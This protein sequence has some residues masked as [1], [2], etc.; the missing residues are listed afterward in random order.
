MK[1]IKDFEDY[2]ITENGE[3]Y[4][5]KYGEPRKMKTWFQN[6]GGY[7]NVKLSK[8]GAVKGKRVHRL[9]AEA[10]V[11][12]PN[13]D[14]YHEVHHIDN[15]PRNNHASNLE[16]C[17]RKYNLSQSYDT[18][19]PVRNFVR[20]ALYSPSDVKLKSFDSIGLASQYSHENFGTSV[21]GM[22][23]NKKSKGYYLKCRD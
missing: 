7:E 9:V 13:P 15:N 20:V 8:N 5:L 14:E 12:N 19:S 11:H 18:M 16:W 23:R 2:L 10:F 21:S 6:H 4:S 17:D 22:I 1:K 3:V